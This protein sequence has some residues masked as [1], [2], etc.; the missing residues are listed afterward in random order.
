MDREKPLLEKEV[1]LYQQKNHKIY[2]L[3]DRDNDFI[4][5][6][7]DWFEIGDILY[8]NDIPITITA[9]I[10]K[11]ENGSTYQIN[12]RLISKV[13]NHFTTNKSMEYTKG[14][15][16]AVMEYKELSKDTRDKLLKVKQLTA[17]LIDLAESYKTV[18]NGREI[19]L[20]QTNYEMAIMF[21]TKSIINE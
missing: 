4:T 6:D 2:I 10:F 13:G 16:M 19:S 14:Q 11:N 21:L 3:E 18:N 17:D 15:K 1:E 20:A 12:H 7:R 9:V 8:Y 5:V